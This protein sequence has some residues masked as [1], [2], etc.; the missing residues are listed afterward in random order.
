MKKKVL[1]LGTSSDKFTQ[2]KLMLLRLKY[3]VID[4]SRPYVAGRA[5]LVMLDLR[6]EE[7][8]CW[9]QLREVRQEQGN[10]PV[11]V[12]GEKKIDYIVTAMKLGAANYMSEPFDA[13]ELK[14]ALMNIIDETTLVSEIAALSEI[15]K[16]QP[17]W[18]LSSCSPAMMEVKKIVE[19]V[20]G[21][22]VTVLI[23]GESGTGKGVIARAIYLNSKRREMPFV[24]INCA[25]LPKELLESELFGYEKGAFTG[26]YQRKAGKF[27]L[28]HE[29]TIFLDEISEMH[30]S[31]QAK[32]LHVL[33]TGEFS[34]IGG[35]ESEKVNVRII[36]A[37]SS[38]L[39]S[40]VRAG[41]FRDDL[42]YRLNVVSLRI[43]ALRERKEEIPLLA[44][45]FLRQ[46][47]QEYNKTYQPLTPETLAAFI[48]YDWPGNVREL[49][50][51]IKRIVILGEEH[52]NLPL[53]F[54]KGATTGQ[55]DPAGFSLKQVSREVSKKLESEV[56]RKVLNQT[57]WNRRKAAEIL[58]ISYRSLL[59]KIKEGGLETSS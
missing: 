43:P 54:S 5:D 44:G 49:E 7:P 48:H 33:E 51:F 37:T 13:Q 20:A 55:A 26:A 8:P 35:E 47:Y 1:L 9:E 2:L 27:G 29:G 42:F 30:P 34:R 24:K 56:I 17:S 18:L 38:H 15:A 6:G 10:V 16:E 25:A 22:D 39:E 59:Y 3:L 4:S 45:Y 46:Y 32:L 41:L 57:R 50:N 12:V 28:A 21:T 53:L 11:V 23:R 19:Q 14:G 52:C 40:A 36:A 58:K 31:L